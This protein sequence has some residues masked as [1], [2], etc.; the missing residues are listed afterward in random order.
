MLTPR[1]LTLTALAGFAAAVAAE[2]APSEPP[3]HQHVHD[4]PTMTGA[5]G[6]YPMTRDASGTSWQ[7]DSTPH[8]MAHVMRGDWMLAG[9]SVLN[10]VHDDQEGRRG[11][12]LEFV[13]GMVMGTARRTWPV[14]DSLTLDRK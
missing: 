2:D 12:E 14:G 9:H 7:P 11:D 10:A 4:G 1:L 6:D 3:L 8:E 5:L 13:A